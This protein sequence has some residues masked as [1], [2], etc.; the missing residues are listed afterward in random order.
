MEEAPG[1]SLTWQER[2]KLK[3]KLAILKQEYKKTFNRLQRSQRVERVKSHVKKKIA[4]QNCSLNEEQSGTDI[5]DLK[6]AQSS[7]VGSLDAKH[8]SEMNLNS[9]K[10]MS[11]SFNLQPEFFNIGSNKHHES[12]LTED[13]CNNQKIPMTPTEGGCA[14]EKNQEK[15]LR[16]REK[17]K[18]NTLE[19]KER[20]STCGC[21]SSVAFMPKGLEGK[22]LD[23]EEQGSPVFKK[24]DNILSLETRRSKSF[25]SLLTANHFMPEHSE[26]NKFLSETV[27]EFS[28]V[29]V[30][31]FPSYPS[32]S[33]SKSPTDNSR[34]LELTPSLLV[35]IAQV[36]PINVEKKEDVVVCNTNETRLEGRARGSPPDLAVSDRYT[37]S[38]DEHSCSNGKPLHN[39]MTEQ[40]SWQ[41]YD[42]KQV[43]SAALVN[44]SSTTVESP[45][46]SCT[47]VE[48]LLFP[49]EYYVRTTRRMSNCQRKVDLEAVIYSH[50]GKSRKGSRRKVKQM[51]K[52]KEGGP[53][54]AQREVKEQQDNNSGLS[55]SLKQ[56]EQVDSS[57]RAE[58]TNLT[59][60]TNRITD[61]CSVSH[62]LIC[63]RLKATKKGRGKRKLCKLKTQLPQAFASINLNTSPSC[64]PMKKESQNGNKNYELECNTTLLNQER[65]LAFETDGAE[66]VRRAKDFMPCGNQALQQ[67][68]NTYNLLTQD[69]FLN[70]LKE[71]MTNDIEELREHKTPKPTANSE[72][73]QTRQFTAQQLITKEFFFSQDTSNSCLHSKRG[74]LLQGKRDDRAQ[75]THISSDSIAGIQS[76]SN[77]PFHLHNEMLGS[78][79][80]LDITDFQL[81]DDEFGFLKLEKLKSPLL[82][83]VEPCVA[84]LFK[85]EHQ[86]TGP[87]AIA[88]VP[89]S[90]A[91]SKKQE[92]GVLAACGNSLSR[93][94]NAESHGPLEQSLAKEFSSSALLSTPA[95]T[96]SLYHAVT[97]PPVDTHTA[98]FPILGLT[99][100]APLQDP[101]KVSQVASCRQ[102]LQILPDSRIKL[103]TDIGQMRDPTSILLAATSDIKSCVSDMMSTE[104]A[105]CVPEARRTCETKVHS[106]ACQALVG[107]SEPHSKECCSRGTRENKGR[108]E[109][110]SSLCD[111]LEEGKE[112]SLQ[113]ISMLQTTSDS[114]AVDV[115]SVWWK[116]ACSSVRELHIVTACESSISFWKPEDPAHWKRIH[117]WSSSKMPVI[118]VVP[119]PDVYCC[120]CI[121]LGSLAIEELWLLFS[122]PGEDTLQDQLVKCGYIYSVLGLA[123]R[124]IVSSSRAAEQQIL[125][126]ISLSEGGRITERQTLM[127]P[128]ESILAFSE[129]KGEKSALIGTT[130]A[131]NIVIWNLVTGQLLKM[132]SIGKSYQAPICHKAY[133]ES[134]LLFIVL[135][136]P[137][138]SECQSSTGAVFTLIASNPKQA[139]S[140]PVM[141]Y[142]LPERS[143]GR[144]LEGDVEQWS[145]AAV[146]TSGSI[147]IWDLSVGLCAA[148]LP[149][150]CD[151]VWALVRWLQPNSCLMAGKKDG[152]VY[153][154]KYQNAY[155]A[156]S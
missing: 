99:P 51:A 26:S 92:D 13:K 83:H 28:P 101:N 82:P 147:A 75:K 55:C 146:L 105:T 126:I 114:P 153:L 21:S 151:G 9:E 66:Q 16:S 64:S 137:Y 25:S 73:V 7:D 118:Q 94:S 10:R 60:S 109:S 148:L 53:E 121:A 87:Y 120:V 96:I 6:E 132:I 48:G 134:G 128:K 154:Y 95:Y 155:A 115:N 42:E 80:C 14:Q 149:P 103:N 47:V 110:V 72:R 59:T 117:T 58:D 119:F 77:F 24:D 3:E 81:P 45:L 49:V 22:K 138:A 57:N 93:A 65:P 52:S 39:N 129:V 19:S 142:I 90:N 50:L 135:S 89:A 112:S 102:E 84:V 152:S 91:K 133:S 122:C 144:Y 54:A 33:Q 18:R 38:T 71:T 141:S 106:Q 34:L 56:V 69:N 143:T 68:E 131:S 62:T 5:S 107:Q 43:E 4:E 29:R 20:K 32:L 97:Q 130:V 41:N 15:S 88:S 36:T 37:S 113:L 123:E 40:P 35:G 17:L 79:K 98:A 78:M 145:A 150:T 2:Q 76:V 1:R 44:V 125:E 23:I 85:D 70:L 139:D 30:T 116:S 63:H 127:P 100:A 108:V 11:V 104:N 124:R 61:M 74:R 8:V 46:N 67:E 86:T 12:S 140:I 156:K 27:K 136:H 31:G 111:I